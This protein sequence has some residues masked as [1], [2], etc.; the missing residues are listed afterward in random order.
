LRVCDDHEGCA[1]AETTIE[2]TN[3]APT[4]AAGPDRSA[5]A[6]KAVS[7]SGSFTDPAP[8]DTHTISWAFSDGGTASGLTPTHVFAV[9][10]VYTA[11]LTVTDDDGDSST[12]TLTVTV[13]APGCVVPRLKGLTLA[14]AKTRLAANHCRLGRVTRA[15]SKTVKKSRILAQTPPAGRKLANGAK[16]NVVLSRGKKPR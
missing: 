9:K 1:T 12:D 3:V 16:V 6:G 10:G 13:A 11:T 7:F 14:A 5:V 2:V 15:Y 8:A 4:A